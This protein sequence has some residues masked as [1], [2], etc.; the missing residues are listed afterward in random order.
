MADNQYPQIRVSPAD[1]EWLRKR[2]ESHRRTLVAE[3][4]AIRDLIEYFERDGAKF[5]V[6]P[7]PE[8]GEII[9][10]IETGK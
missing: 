1:M 9:P 10:V 7:R 8:G 2:A 4:S 5:D 3:F 6:L